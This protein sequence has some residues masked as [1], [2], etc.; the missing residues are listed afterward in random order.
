MEL[1]YPEKWIDERLNL[2]IHFDPDFI[3]YFGHQGTWQVYHHHDVKQV[4]TD[5]TN[6]SSQYTPK[7]ENNPLAENLNQLDPPE[8]GRL[9]AFMTKTFTPAFVKALE[10]WIHLA[11]TRLIRKFDG[12][13][14]DFVNAF[15][16]HLPFNVISMALGIDNS[17]Y[18]QVYNWVKQI[19]TAPS[20][21]EIAT[22]FACQ[23]EILSFFTEEV[24]K[25]K[26]QKGNLISEW[27][28]TQIN[29]EYLSERE[30]ALFCINLYLG[31]TGTL[32]GL[33]QLAMFTL[34]EFPELQ[35]QISQSPNLIPSFIEE[36]LRF[37]TPVPTMYRKA[38][39]DLILSGQPIKE[40]DI[41]T[42]WLCAANRD[43]TVFQSPH[44]FDINREGASRHLSLGHG[45]HHCVGNFLLRTEMK[46]ALKVIFQHLENIQLVGTPKLNNSLLASSFDKLQ[47]QYTI[48]G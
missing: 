15:A 4:L 33:L 40:S 22:Y 26:N 5:H 35:N 8:H 3:T 21:D 16:T 6:F 30:V 31:G 41:I 10:P 23:K 25:K 9:R 14:T 38:K 44:S 13:E 29:K 47:L 18:A 32:S 17:D 37:R 12:N 28:L 42:V 19:A 7:V 39:K 27:L 36:L 1:L 20:P 46:I 45:I 48:R 43:E 11:A 2:G 24:K 34:A